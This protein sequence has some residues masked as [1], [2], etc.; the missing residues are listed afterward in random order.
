[1][2]GNKDV[3][4]TTKDN[5]TVSLEDAHLGKKTASG[6]STTDAVVRAR[7]EPQVSGDREINRN[8]PNL[9]VGRFNGKVPQKL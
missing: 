8:P 9:F 2:T 6:L 1:M 5:L 7:N 3:L 4:S